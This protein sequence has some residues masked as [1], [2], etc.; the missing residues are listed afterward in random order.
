M[1]LLRNQIAF[2][3]A[4]SGWSSVDP[5]LRSHLHS[6]ILSVVI[7]G[8]DDEQIYRCLRITSGI[9]GIKSF[10]SNTTVKIGPQAGALKSSSQIFKTSVAC[11]VSFDRIVDGAT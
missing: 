6:S 7:R 4:R 1:R 9:A 2:L 8:L 3:R 11:H 5:M 10:A